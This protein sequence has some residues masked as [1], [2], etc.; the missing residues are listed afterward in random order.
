LLGEPGIAVEVR[1]GAVHLAPHPTRDALA[2][3]TQGEI[4][5]WLLEPARERA[6]QNP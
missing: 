4:S 3:Q 5:E 1:F 6:S 2:R